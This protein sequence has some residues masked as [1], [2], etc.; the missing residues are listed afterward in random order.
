[1]LTKNYCYYEISY[2]QTLWEVLCLIKFDK[3]ILTPLGGSFCFVYSIIQVMAS[4]Y[5]F[6]VIS[7]EVYTIVHVIICI[8]K[9]YAVNTLDLLTAEASLFYTLSLPSKISS[10]KASWNI[11]LSSMTLRYSIAS[12]MSPSVIWP[13]KTFIFT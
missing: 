6:F 9:K 3:Q 13:P 10:I 2:W 4:Y 7:I 5:S 8:T 12:H 11:V 1:M